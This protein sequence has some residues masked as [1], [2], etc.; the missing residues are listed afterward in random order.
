MT[1]IPIGV[2]AKTELE[3]ELT[4]ELIPSS[5]T[6]TPMFPFDMIAGVNKA[7][8]GIVQ[9]V[10]FFGNPVTVTDDLPVF[11]ESLNSDVIEVPD[12][13]TIKAGNSYTTF[14]ITVSTTEGTTNITA[15]AQ[16]FRDGN[17]NINTKLFSNDLLIFVDSI[18]QP[19][20]F[21][22]EITVKVFVDD[23][24]A[25]SIEGVTL[26]FSG[27]ENLEIS[28]STAITDNTGLATTTIKAIAGPETSLTIQAVK[29]GFASDEVTKNLSVSGLAITDEFLG[30]P[31]WVMYAMIIAIVGAAGAG[32]FFFMKKPKEVIEEEEEEEEI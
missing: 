16:G 24:N 12:N 27:D 4:F 19:I 9:L 8:N 3:T 17:T 5:S 28:P 22:E 20:S 10:D 25:K 11:L 13:I 30:V 29:A 6:I 32:L 31:S 15:T 7:N 18:Q 1:V 2:D 14:P 21:D 23:L 26:T